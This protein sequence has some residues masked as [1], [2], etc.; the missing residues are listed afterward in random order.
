MLS[1]LHV[2]KVFRNNLAG[3]LRPAGKNL[4]HFVT[5]CQIDLHDPDVFLFSRVERH[6]RLEE[7]VVLLEIRMRNFRGSNHVVRRV[8]LFHNLLDRFRVNRPALIEQALDRRFHGR[9]AFAG[10][11]V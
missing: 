3:R 4:F 9:L 11:H 5:V 2:K 6:V 10:S 7:H 8:V 1:T